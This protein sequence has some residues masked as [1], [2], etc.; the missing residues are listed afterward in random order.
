MRLSWACAMT[1]QPGKFSV[2]RSGPLLQARRRA[3]TLTDAHGMLS[4]GGLRER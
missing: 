4:I 3:V 2:S 1:S